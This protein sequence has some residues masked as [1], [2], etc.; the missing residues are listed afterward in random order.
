MMRA[1]DS[2]TSPRPRDKEVKVSPR[3]IKASEGKD[4]KSSIH[5][6]LDCLLA[7]INIEMAVTNVKNAVANDQTLVLR[8]E[9][10]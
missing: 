10:D 7:T 1:K 6:A 2:L 4:G 8:V 5:L 3:D 9:S